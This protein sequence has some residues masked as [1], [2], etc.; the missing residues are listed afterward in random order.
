MLLPTDIALVTGAGRGIGKEIASTLAARGVTTLLV[1]RSKKEIV[2]VRD[3]IMA[4]GGKAFAYVCDLTDKGAIHKLCDQLLD[5]HRS[6]PILINNAGYA[7]SL[8]LEETTEELWQQ[9]MAT[10]V[11]APFLFAKALVPH[12]KEVKRGFIINIAST[13]ALYGFSYASAYCA[14]KHALLGLA[15]ALET[16]LKRYGIR[17]ASIMP[18]FVRTEVLM[19]SVENI[20]KRTG[21]SLDTAEAELAALN[22][23]GRIIEPHEIAKIVAD[24]LSDLIPDDRSEIEIQ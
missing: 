3:E 14:S 2:A 23:S 18:G 4:T 12:M 8:K 13:A 15:R 16:E 21:R 5:E 11:T 20:A 9:M 17:V 7:K 22:R 19:H 1:A 6:I 24:I 10:N